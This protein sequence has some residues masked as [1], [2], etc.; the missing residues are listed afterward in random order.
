MLGHLGQP[1]HLRHL[2][3]LLVKDT[4]NAALGLWAHQEITNLLMLNSD[5]YRYGLL[6]TALKFSIANDVHLVIGI[7]FGLQDLTTDCLDHFRMLHDI[8][9]LLLVPVAK[10]GQLEHKADLIRHSVF[11]TP[12]SRWAIWSC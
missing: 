6:N 2:V 4:A 3:Y 1:R 11:F 12:N 9:H 10:E 7:S 5:W 8:F